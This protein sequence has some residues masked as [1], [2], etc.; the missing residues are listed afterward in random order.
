MRWRTEMKG[1][2]TTAPALW[3]FVILGCAGEP[4]RERDG[5]VRGSSFSNAVNRFPIIKPFF[6]IKEMTR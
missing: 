1:E 3:S 6:P 4:R 5:R 2:K